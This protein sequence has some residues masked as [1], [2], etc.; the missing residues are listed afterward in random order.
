MARTIT[1][2]S[3]RA[4]TAADIERLAD[5]IEREDFDLSTWVPRPGRPRLDP[6]AISHA[7]RIAVRVPESLRLRVAS[8]A[9]AEGRTVSQVVRVLLEQYAEAVR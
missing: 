8:R 1:T 5:H 6:A 7:P 3:G 4:L 9:A 2:K